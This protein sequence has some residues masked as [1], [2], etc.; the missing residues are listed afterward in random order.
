MI[1]ACLD[2]KVTESDETDAG[3]E[4]DNLELA[5]RGEHELDNTVM[6]VA[7]NDDHYLEIISNSHQVFMTR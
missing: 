3:C 5:H 7:I 6:T 1:F 4:N 2:A